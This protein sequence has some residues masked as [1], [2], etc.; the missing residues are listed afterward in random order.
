MIN[1]TP[2]NPIQEL[3]LLGDISCS[4]F[5]CR[6][7]DGDGGRD[8]LIGNISG[9]IFGGHHDAL[10]ELYKVRHLQ[11]LY[12]VRHLQEL[13]NFTFSPKMS[14]DANLKLGETINGTAGR[15]I[16]DGNGNKFI[17]GTSH[18]TAKSSGSGGSGQASASSGDDAGAAA[19][20]ARL[21]RQ[22]LMI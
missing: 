1:N 14:G 20:Y 19:A 9:S 13:D 5:G 8:G 15:V 18:S 21:H 7:H 16:I 12:R 10:E 6:H 2:V 22:M 3:N 17:Q 11:E 4:I